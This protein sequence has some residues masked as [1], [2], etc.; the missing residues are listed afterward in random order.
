MKTYNNKQNLK[1]KLFYKN[2]EKALSLTRA[3]LPKI[4]HKIIMIK[5]SPHQQN[6]LN[7]INLRPINMPVEIRYQK[8]Y[9]ISTNFNLRFPNPFF[10]RLLLKLK[11]LNKDL[12][13][14]K[15]CRTN[16]NLKKSK[17]PL[18]L[19]HNLYKLK[20]SMPRKMRKSTS[21]ILNLN[22][23]MHI[24]KMMTL[25]FHLM[26]MKMNKNL[27]Y[28]NSIRKSIDRLLKILLNYTNAMTLFISTTGIKKKSRNK[29]PKS[30]TLSI[31]ENGFLK[32]LKLKSKIFLKEIIYQ[33]ST[34]KF[35]SLYDIINF[36]KQTNFFFIKH[37]FF[38]N[39]IFFYYKFK[40]NFFFHI[41]F[42][43][44]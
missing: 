35:S 18:F 10:L 34:F 21:K 2:K 23:E 20:S 3:E 40:K 12:K 11:K 33:K 42:Y 31:S 36:I 28:T 38:L 16:F 14:V 44:I 8:R 15:K 22:S 24:S 9:W 17:K 19:L 5:A 7:L 4:H 43:I 6:L 30:E 37:N 1:N 25:Y 39:K 13:K 26:T 27:N 32:K 29:K 41:N